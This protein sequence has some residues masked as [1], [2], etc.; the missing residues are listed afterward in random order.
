MQE[1]L[2]A[3]QTVEHIL[4]IDRKNRKK[5]RSNNEKNNDDRKESHGYAP[6]WSVDRG[7]LIR[8]CYSRKL[9]RIV[10]I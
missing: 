9:Q 5:K 10:N 1:Y 2:V 8:F 3:K 4:G 6:F 7:F